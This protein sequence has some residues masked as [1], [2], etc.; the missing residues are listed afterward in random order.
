MKRAGRT[1]DHRQHHF[2]QVIIHG[3]VTFELITINQF[4]G[5][6]GRIS[7]EPAQQRVNLHQLP[8]VRVMRARHNHN[9][10]T[11]KNNIKKS[12][13]CFSTKIL[14]FVWNLKIYLL[15]FVRNLKFFFAIYV[16]ILKFYFAFLVWIL[17]FCT[18]PCTRLLSKSVC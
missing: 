7:L 18:K 14:R 12:L 15:I 3:I 13:H 8:L 11:Y 16:W 1:G 4:K 6:I 9:G 17:K 10:N 5:T 2:K